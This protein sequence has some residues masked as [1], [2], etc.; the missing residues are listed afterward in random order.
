[1]GAVIETSLTVVPS[2]RAIRTQIMQQRGHDGFLPDYITMFEFLQRAV[3]VEGYRRIDDDTRTLLL[4]EASDFSRFDTLRI[5]RNFFAF[6]QSS[7][8]IFRFFEELGGELV[9]METLDMADTYG[10][11]EEHIAILRELYTRYRNICEDK[12]ILDPV[13]LRHHYRLNQSY[14]QK[15][16]EIRVVVEGYLTELEMQ[17]LYECSRITAVQLQFHA[18]PYNKKMQ[19]KLGEKGFDIVQEYDHLLDLGGTLTKRSPADASTASVD[20][21]AYAERIMQVAFIKQRVYEYVRE[22]IAPENIAVILPDESF[23]AYLRRFDREGNYN[24]A[25]GVSL[26]ESNTLRRLQAVCEWLENP[27]VQ[28]GARLNRLGGDLI[29]HIAPHYGKMMKELDF[30][31]LM[32][33][34]AACEEDRMVR[35]VVKEE[36]YYFKQLEGVLQEMSLKTALHLFMN[37]LRSRSVDDVGGGKITV[38]GV[39]ES[40]CVSFEGV[41]VVD[42]NEGRVPRR[43][44]KDLFLN[45][46]TRKK[47]GLPS[48]SDRE[49]LQKHYYHRLFSRAKRVSIAYVESSDAIP[50]RFIKQM[51]LSVSKQCADE[52][53]LNVMFDVRS[54]HHVAEEPVEAGYDFTLRPLSSSA[55]SAFLR[56]RRKFYHRYVEA[57]KAHELPR[58]LP[59]EWEIGN[60]VH[61][62]LKNVY[63]VRSAYED[64]EALRH[65]VEKA[66]L[67]CSGGSVLEAYLLKLWK[68]R[69]MPFYE[70][71]MQR[72]AGGATVKSCER[73]FTGSYGGLKLTGRIDRIDDVGG[74]LEVLD[75]KTGSFDTYTAKTVEGATDFQLEFYALLAS[76][77]GEVGMCGYYDLRSGRIVPETLMDAKMEL[78]GGHL[79]HLSKTKYFSFDKTDRLAE[80]RY[81]EFV[82][83][84]GRA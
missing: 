46:A 40:R 19:N 69:L 84:C 44:E 29:G 79:E 77:L 73:E 54:R 49:A 58:D 12:K 55:L 34:F 22:G 39:L 28:N 33:P 9:D 56:C 65:D 66:L 15:L 17:I 38:M 5:D 78:L 36:L 81:C 13:F 68:R 72:F 67:A 27:T 1:M 24:F 80:C 51:G 11:Y 52:R 57:L 82:H 74:V 59:E 8:Y 31:M 83:L 71:E 4:L 26:Q 35:D 3:T 61:N 6:T 7:S 50:S 2:S 32:E 25:M 30:M 75:Y 18:S 14:I 53:F 16:G 41:V 60:I 45:S 76:Q 64:R 63:E 20:C 21:V 62:A 48:A 23:A 70:N 47:A 42:F 37:R 43:S 10:D